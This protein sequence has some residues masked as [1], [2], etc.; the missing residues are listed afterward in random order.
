MPLFAGMDVSGETTELLQEFGRL[1]EKW[2]P[3]INLIARSTV[4]DLWNRH[5]LDSAQVYQHAPAF[6]KWTD[7]GSGGG[8]PGIVMA[9]LAREK[10][11]SATLT[12]IESDTRK[13]TFLRTA[14]RELS[15]TV[16]VVS[17]RIEVAS[18]TGADVVSARALGSMAT[19]LPLLQHHLSPDGTALLMKGR[20]FAEELSEVSADWDFDLKQY[21]S[22][23]DPDSRIL[24]LQRISR[25]A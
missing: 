3:K 9:I 11:P 2:T 7:I 10:N 25:V 4:P 1:V 21:P 8:F 6:E 24:S 18:P 15:L 19:L 13:A 20:R 22:I 12:L 23:T 14:A 16:D 17:E 5:I